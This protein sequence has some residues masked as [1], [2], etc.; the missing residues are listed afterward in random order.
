MAY[1]PVNYKRIYL[2]TFK[3][4]EDTVKIRKETEIQY[5]F[6]CDENVSEYDVKEEM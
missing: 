6:T 2:G 5:L 1:I 4:Y 3:N